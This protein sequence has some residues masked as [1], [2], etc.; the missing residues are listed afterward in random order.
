MIGIKKNGEIEFFAQTSHQSCNLT[1]SHKL[2]LALG[3]TNEDRYV[4]F[5]GSGEHRFQ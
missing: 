2:A 1:N 4:Q 5:P 3:Q